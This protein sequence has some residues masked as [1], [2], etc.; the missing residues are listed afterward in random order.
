[1]YKFVESYEKSKMES[2]TEDQT[3]EQYSKQ[4]RIKELK[5]LDKAS[6]DPQNIF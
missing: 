6:S 1:M 5:H 4:G 3:K 2:A